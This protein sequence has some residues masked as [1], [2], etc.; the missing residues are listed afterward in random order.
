ML[1]CKARNIMRNEAYFSYAAKTNDARNAADVRFSTACLS[2]ARIQMTGILSAVFQQPAER[3]SM[4]QI[5]NV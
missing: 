1:R 2:T 3:T 4:E 5:F